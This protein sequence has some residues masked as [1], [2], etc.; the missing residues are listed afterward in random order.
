MPLSLAVPGCGLLRQKTQSLY[1][2]GAVLVATIDD[3]ALFLLAAKSSL[4]LL[5]VSAVCTGSDMRQMAHL[6]GSGGMETVTAGGIT[7]TG[8]A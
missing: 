7:G 6:S 3:C 5:L 2:P 4:L 8:T 1:F